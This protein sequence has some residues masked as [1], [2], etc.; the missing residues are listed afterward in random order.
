LSYQELSLKMIRKLKD[1]RS[2]FMTIF[3]LQA[4]LVHEDH[5]ISFHSIPLNSWIPALALS[6]FCLA[7]GIF[8]LMVNYKLWYLTLILSI[9]A[10]LLTHR[11]KHGM[12]WEGK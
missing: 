6:L 5:V 7:L 11:A 8:L 9:S 3:D 1:L 12:R 10:G 2:S 4:G